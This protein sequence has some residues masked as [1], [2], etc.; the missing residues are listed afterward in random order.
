MP[1]RSRTT[2]PPPPVDTDDAYA[3][4]TWGSDNNG[5][6]DLTVPSGQRCLVKRPGVQGL[7]VAGVLHNLD[8]LTTL[9][10]EKHI[11]R[12]SGQAEVD[13]ASLLGDEQN[14][15]KILHT[16]DRVVAHVVVKPPVEMAPNDVTL[17]QP[18][19]VYT[20]MVDVED[21]MFIFQFV[22]GGTADLERFRDQLG[23]SVGSI[24]ASENMAV[25]AQ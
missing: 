10:S 12:V 4:T 1:P 13:V 22:V 2:V 7:M 14:L 19:Q 20:D 24:P 18:G 25:Q 21:K 15:L 5:L 8:T 6:H 17:R 23:E 9:V 11:K 16:V 3:P